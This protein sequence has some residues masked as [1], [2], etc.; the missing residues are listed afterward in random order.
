M[1]R[2]T[3]GGVSPHSGGK[4]KIKRWQKYSRGQTGMRKQCL[5]RRADSWSH[6]SWGCQVKQ[7]LN[8]TLACSPLDSEI[9]VRRM[10][11]SKGPNTTTN[12]CALLK[13]TH[14]MPGML[15]PNSPSKKASPHG[16]LPPNS[17]PHQL[18]LKLL[19]ATFVGVQNGHLFI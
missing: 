6:W 7:K 3:D 17:P 2:Q 5:T 8:E 12:L 16:Q 4:L 14:D 11:Q 18:S 15:D 10:K 19:L 13:L 9:R 1:D